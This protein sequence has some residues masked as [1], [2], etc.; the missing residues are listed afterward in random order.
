MKA[1]KV[2]GLTL[3]LNLRSVRN[4]VLIEIKIRKVII[5]WSEFWVY[6]RSIII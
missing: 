2:V 3:G 1:F 5:D 6:T 4:E